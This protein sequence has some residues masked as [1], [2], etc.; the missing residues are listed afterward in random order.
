MK[1]VTVKLQISSKKYTAAQQ[2]MQEKGLLIEDEL[3]DFTLKLYQNMFQRQ[4][5]STSKR[6]YQRQSKRLLRYRD[7]LEKAEKMVL[8][9][10]H[11]LA[12]D[13]FSE[14][15]IDNRLKIAWECGVQAVFWFI[16]STL[17]YGS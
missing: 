14:K 6:L 5:E 3:S 17:K 16:F 11:L 15:S 4:S 13:R 7:L 1:P 2:F 9:Q 12:F 10:T 8:D